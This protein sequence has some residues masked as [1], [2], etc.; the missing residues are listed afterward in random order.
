MNN[1]QNHDDDDFEDITD[2]V[3]GAGEINLQPITEEQR[4]PPRSEEQKWTPAS[5]K[6][7]LIQ[8]LRGLEDPKHQQRYFDSVDRAGGSAD[9]ANFLET[10]SKASSKAGSIGGLEAGSALQGMGDKQAKI[11]EA[12]L[13][14]LDKGEDAR[15]SQIQ[16]LYQ[17]LSDQEARKERAQIMGDATKEGLA[18]KSSEGDANRKNALAIA[19]L[20]ANSRADLAKAKSDH[21]REVSELKETNKDEFKKLPVESQ[22]LIRDLSKKNA[23]KISIGSSIKGYLE[24]FKAAP[25]SDEKIII[26]RQ[27]L[28]VLNSPEGA[29]AIGVEEAK[30]L[31][32]LLE[33]QIGNLRNP[34]PFI[35]RDLE[36]FEKQIVA[37]SNAVQR[38]VA[39]NK[40]QIDQLYGRSGKTQP[41]LITPPGKKGA[42]QGTA[43]AKQKFPAGT[44]KFQDESGKIYYILP[45]SN[46]RV[47]K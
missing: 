26:G 9:S 21:Q 24:E 3:L 13:G 40:N 17:T 8:H 43:G 14:R 32:S 28:K 38:S 46:E 4:V 34:G 42:D 7:R 36:G 16:K 45:G 22:E 35:G 1:L 44:K 10:L 29:D 27:M 11:A 20:N 6:E 12:K 25:S 33:F 47:Y 2:Q 31:G 18:A 30:R 15:K 23:S 37:T 5:E 19:E 39:S 41:S